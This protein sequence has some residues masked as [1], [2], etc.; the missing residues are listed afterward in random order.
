MTIEVWVPLGDAR[1]RLRGEERGGWRR[2]R[3]T[4]YRLAG[5]LGRRTGEVIWRGFPYPVLETGVGRWSI[6]LW[7]FPP[8]QIERVRIPPA[9]G[10]ARGMWREL[11]FYPVR[12]RVGVRR[13]VLGYVAWRG[14]LHRVGRSRHGLEL[15]P[16]VRQGLK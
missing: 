7:A 12:R 14:R 10:Q 6:G 4:V 5:E 13:E 11:T 9:R 2:V 1:A 3:R 16:P 15:L 8:V